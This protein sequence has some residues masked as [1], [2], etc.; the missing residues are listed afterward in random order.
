MKTK[1]SVIICALLLVCC[2][3]LVAAT[4]APAQKWEYAQ[5]S[6][7]TLDASTRFG[8]RSP[9]LVDSEVVKP[10][11][12]SDAAFAKLYKVIGGISQPIAAKEGINRYIDLDLLNAIGSQGWE[13]VSHEKTQPFDTE[14]WTFKRAH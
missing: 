7:S 3:M 8:F 12:D 6:Y 4:G 2:G 1:A 11:E 13:L 14:T 10:G 9:E 5:L